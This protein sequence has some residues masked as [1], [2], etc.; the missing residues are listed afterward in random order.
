[1]ATLGPHVKLPTEM[2]N[3]PTLGGPPGANVKLSKG[4]VK[5]YAWLGP[6]YPPHVRMPLSALPG[7]GGVGVGRCHVGLR[8]RARGRTPY[9]YRTAYE[10]R[11]RELRSK[12]PRHATNQ[13]TLGYA[14]PTATHPS[15]PLLGLG[16][17]LLCPLLL[18]VVGL[19]LGELL[20]KLLGLL[21]LGL[22][23]SAAVVR[24]WSLG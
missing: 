4:S 9:Y 12:R 3:F 2:S 24:P 23:A 16:T 20:C 6:Y 1:M 10:P 5:V 19:P 13:S 21:L 11:E 7:G 22:D 8:R 15:S 14:T 18:F 17:E